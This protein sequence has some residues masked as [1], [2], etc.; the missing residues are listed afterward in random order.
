[1]QGF[2]CITMSSHPVIFGGFLALCFSLLILQT[3]ILRLI[4][5]YLLFIFIQGLKH[6]VGQVADPEP[7]WGAGETGVTDMNGAV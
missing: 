1:M 3:S 7:M 2:A 5:K 4:I 6:E